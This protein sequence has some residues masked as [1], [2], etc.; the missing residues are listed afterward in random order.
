MKPLIEQMQLKM[1]S[2]KREGTYGTDT[3]M[4]LKSLAIIHFR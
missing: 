4:L 1:H 2:D 3:D